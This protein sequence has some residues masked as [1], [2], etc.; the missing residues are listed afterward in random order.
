MRYR[1]L[2]FG[3]IAAYRSQHSCRGGTYIG[4]HHDKDR[5]F[6]RQ[7]TSIY[8]RYCDQ[9]YR[10][11]RLYHSSKHQSYTQKNPVIKMCICSEIYNF[12]ESSHISLHELYTPEQETKSN[13]DVGSFLE[14]CV[15]DNGQDKTSQ[16]DQWQS[17]HSQIHTTKSDLGQHERDESN[18]DIHTGDHAQSIQ[19]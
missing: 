1:D 10:Q 16:S 4:S 3:H 7:Y 19:Q 6:K 11:A 5:C 9:D 14:F 8:C 15:F 13:R 18:T 2:L 12:L 17:N